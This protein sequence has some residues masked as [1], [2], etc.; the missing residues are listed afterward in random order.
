MLEIAAGARESRAGNAPT[1]SAAAVAEYERL[2]AVYLAARAAYDADAATYWNSIAQKRR[3]RSAK[4]SSRTP[5]AL[6]DYELTQPPVYSGPPPPVNPAAPKKPPVPKPYV[7]VIADFLNAAKQEYGFV[8][9]QPPSDLDFKRAYAKV[10]LAAGLTKNQIV[11]VYSFEAS[12]N[13]TYTVQAGLEYNTPSAH[14]ITTALGYNQLL[15]TNSIELM[16]ESGDQ[17]LNALKAKAQQ[18][19]QEKR[20]LLNKVAVVQKMVEYATSVPDDWSQHEVLAN[21]PKGLAIHAMNL[22]IDVGPMLQTEKLLMSVL[23][24]RK[25]GHDAELTAAELEMMNLSG[26]G[27]GLDMVVMPQD[28]RIQVPTSNFFQRRGYD[29][30]PVAQRNNVVAKLIAATNAAMDEESKKQGA[31]DLAAAC[32]N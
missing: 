6:D 9:Q 21:T 15:N 24:A 4:R 18:S 17:F 16:A 7:A 27:N 31:K 11:R 30:N 1:P 29:D 10:A 28:W 8:P 19:S 20:L 5:I 12:G 25:H 26:D 22:D 3:V 14:A 13:G 32:G 23:F 2:L